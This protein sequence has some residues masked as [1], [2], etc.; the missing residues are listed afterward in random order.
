M[1]I[2]AVQIEGVV[3]GFE[4]TQPRQCLLSILV[5]QLRDTIQGQGVRRQDWWGTLRMEQSK[6]AGTLEA[7][8]A[9]RGHLEAAECAKIPVASRKRINRIILA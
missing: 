1:A 4:G 2:G 9:R 5:S 6:L 7:C 3:Q 8:G